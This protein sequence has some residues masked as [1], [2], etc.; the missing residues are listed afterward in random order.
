LIDTRVVQEPAPD[1]VA[2]WYHYEEIAMH[3]NTLIMQFR[4]QVIGGVG[5]LGTLAGYL[6]GEKVKNIQQQ[7]WLRALISTG[8]WVL[9]VAA[10]ILDLAYYNRLLRGSVAALLQFEQQ[11]PEIQMSTQIEATVGQGKYAAAASYGLMLGVL[12]LFSGW[13][14][15][16]FLCA[17]KND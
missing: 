17:R 14:W 15:F 10:A 11:H 8:L 7:D 6:I 5:A 2:L 4:L 3:F 12:G 13:A 9:I 1:V 16:R